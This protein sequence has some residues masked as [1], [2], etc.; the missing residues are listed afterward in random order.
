MI[1]RIQK[2]SWI[3]KPKPHKRV[4]TSNG[5]SS[6]K[7]RPYEEPLKTPFLLPCIIEMKNK[8]S[9]HARTIK[10]KTKERMCEKHQVNQLGVVFF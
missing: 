7:N 6:Y 1:K 2:L 4:K 8:H 3:L 9:K 5:R 10:K